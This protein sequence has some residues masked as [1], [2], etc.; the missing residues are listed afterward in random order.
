MY[1]CLLS[2]VIGDGRNSREYIP[3]AE[4]AELGASGRAALTLVNDRRAT[5]DVEVARADFA[6]LSDFIGECEG[7]R[8]TAFVL[9][10]L[11]SSSPAMSR[12]TRTPAASASVPIPGSTQPS[13]GVESVLASFG[14]RF[15]VAARSPY[16]TPDAIYPSSTP[17]AA[18]HPSY[19]GV[20]FAPSTS[21]PTPA[22]R[23]LSSQYQPRVTRA[24]TVD[25]HVANPSVSTS[26]VR[27]RRS[28]AHFPR[29]PPV[30]SRTPTT[31]PTRRPS[32]SN[33]FTLPPY[34]T[35]SVLIG[36][37]VGHVPEPESET[38]T[39]SS[40][41][42]VPRRAPSPA[43]SSDSED[44]ALSYPHTRRYQPQVVRPASPGPLSLDKPLQLPTQWNDEDKSR[45]LSISATGKDV[46]FN[47]MPSDS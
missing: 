2:N 24:P 14:D 46:T 1:I 43:R 30:A 32:T 18:G 20:A 37:M 10:L 9:S 34:L 8:H 33:V 19:G 47:G 21:G 13:S 28:S 29:P 45:H 42:P 44:D 31:Q 39:R 4:R 16:G 23:S 6:C 22:S 41:A 35:N 11:L 3:V 12:P 5:C 25:I 7:P 40:A 36:R 26:P 27:N 15:R 17:S 38:P